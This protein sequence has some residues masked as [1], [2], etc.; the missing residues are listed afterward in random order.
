MAYYYIAQNWD[1]YKTVGARYVKKIYTH[2][3]VNLKNMFKIGDGFPKI[4]LPL[5]RRVFPQLI[6]N[7][8]VGVQPMSSFPLGRIFSMRGNCTPR[9][10]K[11]I[12]HEI[13]FKRKRHNR[14]HHTKRNNIRIELFRAQIKTRFETN[15]FNMVIFEMSMHNL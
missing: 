7:E 10:E 6:A 1:I 3:S 9:K 2:N 14:Q 12:R 5:I 15:D 13:G 8:I 11:H 4:A